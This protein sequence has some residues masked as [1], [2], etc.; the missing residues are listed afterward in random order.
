MSQDTYS[1]RIEDLNVGD[2]FSLI[3]EFS[4]EKSQNQKS[5]ITTNVF[6]KTDVYSLN[7]LECFISEETFESVYTHVPQISMI[8]I[9]SF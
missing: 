5:E 4:G 8:F 9:R 6:R 2:H 7:Y 3:I 1:E